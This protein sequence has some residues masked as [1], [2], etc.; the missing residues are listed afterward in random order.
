MLF[1]E[2]PAVDAVQSRAVHNTYKRVRN[3]ENKDS[4]FKTSHDNIQLYVLFSVSLTNND[5]SNF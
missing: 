1:E 3:N 5:I 4:A 2:A